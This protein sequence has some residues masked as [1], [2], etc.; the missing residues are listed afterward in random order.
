MPITAAIT[1]FR[2]YRIRTKRRAVNPS[3]MAIKMTGFAIDSGSSNATIPDACTGT[4]RR[5][6]PIS[7]ARSRSAMAMKGRRFFCST[8]YL[9]KSR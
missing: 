1:R 5:R 6:A 4:E 8:V 9:R 3:M 7:T 2:S